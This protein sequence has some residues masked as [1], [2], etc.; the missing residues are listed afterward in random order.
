VPCKCGCANTFSDRDAESDVKEYRK[1]GPDA[2]T[3]ALIDAILAEGIEG[4]TLLDIGAGIGAIQLELLKAGAA[5]AESVDASE[6]YVEANRAEAARNGFA[7]RTNPRLGDFVALADEVAPADVV[8]LDRVVCC[9]SDANALLT[10]TADHAGR[11]VGLVYPRVRWWIR[12][13]AVVGNPFF[14]LL[15]RPIT[16][17]VHPEAVVDGPLRE[18][19]FVRR[20]IT[21]TVFWQV[22]LYV[23]A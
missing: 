21:R 19:G 16:F 8:T 15:R 2:T 20:P 4:A 12:A 14:R 23:R 6:G 18:A 7:D 17:W 3:Q 11:M 22:V 10:R 13:L 5:R 9:Y 1:N